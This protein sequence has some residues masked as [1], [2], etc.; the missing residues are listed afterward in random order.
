[1]AKDK[2]PHCGEMNCYRHCYGRDSGEHEAKPET[3][4]FGANGPHG[5]IIDINCRWCGQTG[6]VTCLLTEVQWE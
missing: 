4:H 2:C 3:A 5:L 6:G 1:M